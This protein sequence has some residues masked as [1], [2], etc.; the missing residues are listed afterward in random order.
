L[1]LALSER[2]WGGLNTCKLG[3]RLV[4]ET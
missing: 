1:I 4:F 3:R 2:Y